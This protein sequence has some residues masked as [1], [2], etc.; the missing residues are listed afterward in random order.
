[1]GFTAGRSKARPAR[2]I[3]PLAALMLTATACGAGDD[4]GSSASGGGGDGG[5][6]YEEGDQ[7]ELVVPFGEGG[8]TDTTARLVAPFLAENMG[9]D[10][11]VVNV[12]GGGSILGANRYVNQTE[13]NGD[14]WLITSASTQVPVIVGQQGVEFS[15]DDL[16]PV[17]GF[18]LGGVIYGHTDNDVVQEAT[19]LTGEEQSAQFTYAGQPATGG[20]LRILLIFEMFDSDVNTVLGY[21]G[22]GPARVAWEQGESDLGYDTAPAYI[23]SVEPLVEDGTAQALMSFGAVEGGEVVRDPQ[24]P[25]LPSPVEVYEEAYGEAPS[26]EALNAYKTMAVATISLNKAL[27]LHADAPES[28]KEELRAAWDDLAE[29]QE[30]LDAADAELGGY[31][32][33]L[34]DD[35]E[36]AWDELGNVD[37]GDIDWLLQWVEETYDVRLNEASAD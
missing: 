12:P 10:I 19:D 35:A 15:F 30:F 26:G 3:A 33:L 11:Q 17:A 4:G 21:D 16:T 34:R 13:A 31:D 14:S 28:C 1:M 9:I 29:N 32:I 7:V 5:T 37:Q 25:D 6:C 8:G 24:F 18:P 2:A 23:E 27:T 22:R 20:E 36:E